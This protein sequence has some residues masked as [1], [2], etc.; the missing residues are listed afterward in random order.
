MTE[1]SLK[2]SS[3]NR[4]NLHREKEAQIKEEV[5]QTHNNNNDLALRDHKD[6]VVP[7]VL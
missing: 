3:V 1:K 7:R 2:N 4:W 6:Q 5:P